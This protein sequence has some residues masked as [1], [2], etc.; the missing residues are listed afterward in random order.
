MMRT[1]YNCPELQLV[2]IIK[3]IS[4]TAADELGVKDFETK[5]FSNGKVFVCESLAFHKALGNRK[6]GLGFLNPFALF[7]Q[8]KRT[9]AK[10]VDYNMKG[11]GLVQGGFIVLS[12]SAVVYEKQEVTGEDPAVWLPDVEGAVASIYGGKGG[13]GLVAGSADSTPSSLSPL[14]VSSPATVTSGSTRMVCNED[15]CSMEPIHDIKSS[16]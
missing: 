11:E 6:V 13:G 15:M 2:A 16:L 7:S 4:S 9:G 5:Y 14:G 8:L 3:E 1:K 10:G 12:S